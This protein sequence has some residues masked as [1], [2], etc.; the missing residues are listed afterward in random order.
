MIRRIPSHL[1]IC[2]DVFSAVTLGNPLPW[3]PN[4]NVRNKK[5]LILVLML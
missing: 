4:L 3:M 1:H 5:G 2:W